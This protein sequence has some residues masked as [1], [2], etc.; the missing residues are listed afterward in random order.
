[1]FLKLEKSAQEFYTST[2]KTLPALQLCWFWL[3]IALSS[4][5]NNNL[6]IVLA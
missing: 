3:H 2:F 1:V 5:Q 4:H 6:A